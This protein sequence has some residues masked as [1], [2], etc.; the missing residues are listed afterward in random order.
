MVV[1][2]FKVNE[3]L[4]SLQ[5]TGNKIGNKGG[6]HFAAMLQINNCLEE[7]DLGDCDLVSATIQ[8]VNGVYVD[9]RVVYHGQEP[10]PKSLVPLFLY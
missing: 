7:L 5:M 3:T 4:K 2:V 6:M 8:S 10:N 1:N 9:K